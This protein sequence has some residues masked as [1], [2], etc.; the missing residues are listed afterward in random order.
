MMNRE[1]FQQEAEAAHPA[2]ARGQ[3]KRNANMKRKQMILMVMLMKM[4]PMI[5]MISM[6][7]M[8]F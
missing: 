2:P 3:W 5:S 6:I 1:E 7:S 4:V 8:V